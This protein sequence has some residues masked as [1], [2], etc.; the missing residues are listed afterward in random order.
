MN[1]SGR[2]AQLID[3][4][5]RFRCMPP[6]W[7]TYH[8]S[9]ESAANMLRCTP[10]DVVS[11]TEYGLT[12]LHTVDGPRFDYFDVMNV[13]RFSGTGVTVPELNATALLR[14]S[15]RPKSTWLGPQEWTLKVRLP[16]AG[17]TEAYRVR[18]PDFASAGITYLG[19]SIQWPA[20]DRIERS[21]GYAVNVGIDGT[22]DPV[23][24]SVALG[25]YED[26]FHQLRSGAVIYQAVS[27]PLRMEH[28]RAWQ[29][30]IADCMVT[31]R[32]LAD[33]L[34]A[35]GVQ[36]R[37]RRGFILGLVGSEH[38]WCEVH[39]EGRWKSVDVTL[40]AMPVG[41]PN[42]Q[43]LP[44]HDEFSSYCL[45]GRLNRCLP[46]VAEDATALMYDDQGRP[47][48]MIGIISATTGRHHDI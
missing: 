12:S 23:R 30:G 17:R 46:C 18:I 39:E 35:L 7:A 2:V 42:G 22:Y 36:A 9:P 41:L 10:D 44:S 3:A 16:D 5:E 21:D 38:A 4:L 33:R 27:E 26:V 45:G 34:Q 28:Q 47:L 1:S 6:Q 48:P 31:S 11:L 25:I 43:R 32:V 24:N 40:A 8:T 20:D 14:F 19:G 37:A 15:R 29:M 13:G